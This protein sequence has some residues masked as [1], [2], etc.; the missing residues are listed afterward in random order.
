MLHGNLDRLLEARFLDLRES[1]HREYSAKL[2]AEYPQALDKEAKRRACTEGY[3]KA[4]LEG[5]VALEAFR[6]E[7]QLLIDQKDRELASVSYD[8]D[9]YQLQAQQRAAEQAIQKTNFTEAC[10][11]L[12]VVESEMIR[13]RNEVASRAHLVYSKEDL[14][15]IVEEETVTNPISAGMLGFRAERDEFAKVEKRLRDQISSPRMTPVLAGLSLDSDSEVRQEVSQNVPIYA[16]FIGAK[17]KVVKLKIKDDVCVFDTVTGYTRL[18]YQAIRCPAVHPSNV[19]ERPDND[20][21]GALAF[22]VLICS[23]SKEFTPSQH[24]TNELDVRKWWTSAATASSLEGQL[25]NLRRPHPLYSAVTGEVN[26]VNRAMENKRSPSRS[27]DV[28]SQNE[29]GTDKVKHHKSGSSSPNV[30]S[31]SGSSVASAAY[32]SACGSGIGSPAYSSVCASG[33]GSASAGHNSRGVYKAGS[34]RYGFDQKASGNTSPLEDD[35]GKNVA[36]GLVSVSQSSSVK[37]KSGK[38]GSAGKRN[39]DSVSV[40]SSASSTRKVTPEMVALWEASPPAMDHPD[41]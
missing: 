1:V 22:Q 32:A 13:Y 18:R 6:V 21:D 23:D 30:V 37:S 3:Q 29:M 12:N 15:R 5:Q 7:T 4:E 35:V 31:P 19:F 20:R 10:Q 25:Q 38:A 8:R 28:K 26:K 9:Q 36:K 24:Q 41:R 33:N 14:T 40:S 11:R 2:T 17:D 16:F 27:V 39:D 34:Y